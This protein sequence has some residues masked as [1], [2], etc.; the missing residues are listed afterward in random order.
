MQHP[1]ARHPL[2]HPPQ[3]RQLSRLPKEESPA[4]RPLQPKDE[5]LPERNRRPLHDQEELDNTYGETQ[6]IV[7]A[8]GNE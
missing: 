8:I 4:P 1:P 6:R 5:Q 2:S 3:I 7:F